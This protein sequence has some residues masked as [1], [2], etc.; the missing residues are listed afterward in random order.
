M[1][2]VS[3]RSSKCREWSEADEE[4]TEGDGYGSGVED[5]AGDM[6]S[7]IEEDYIDTR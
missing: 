7:D 1:T 3:C 6:V 2:M 5:E 4:V